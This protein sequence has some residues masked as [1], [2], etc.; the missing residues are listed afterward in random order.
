[1]ST[2]E[3]WKKNMPNLELVNGKKLLKS[4][5]KLMKQKQASSQANK[6]NTKNK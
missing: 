4:K 1:M 2:L 5:Q 3:P 6:T